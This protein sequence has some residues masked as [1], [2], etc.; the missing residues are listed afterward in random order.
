MRAT[1]NVE[2]TSEE[3]T[4][5]V[6]QWANKAIVTALSSALG[7]VSRSVSPSMLNTLRDAFVQAA[8]GLGAVPR[9]APDS[10]PPAPPVGPGADGE[11]P[12][13]HC[14]PV[15][16]PH[17]EPGWGCHLCRTYNG[18]QRSECRNCGHTR[19]A[20]SAPP[21]DPIPASPDPLRPAPFTA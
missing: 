18:L 3:L 1:V 12:W 13:V 10:P 21:R 11:V 4:R 6:E 19:C 20:P 17:V 5:F 8:V 2:F 9:G 14:I 16:S 7:S 15:E